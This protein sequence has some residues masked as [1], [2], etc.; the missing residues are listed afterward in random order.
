[1]RRERE[2]A[3]AGIPPD[4]ERF[5]PAINKPVG[6]SPQ[7]GYGPPNIPSGIISVWES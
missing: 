4:P 7:I 3:T 1:L 2:E 6:Y 5:L